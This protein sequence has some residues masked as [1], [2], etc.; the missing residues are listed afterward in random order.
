MVHV[1]DILMTGTESSLRMIQTKLEEIFEL[2]YQ[3]LAPQRQHE[4]EVK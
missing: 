2:K 3:I 1:D 4:Q